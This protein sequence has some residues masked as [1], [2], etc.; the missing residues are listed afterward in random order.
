MDLAKSQP[1]H[2]LFGASQNIILYSRA[3]KS[4]RSD[5]RQHQ[6]WDKRQFGFQTEQKNQNVRIRNVLVQISEVELA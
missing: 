5:F 4:E 6:N 2:F 1:R 3:P